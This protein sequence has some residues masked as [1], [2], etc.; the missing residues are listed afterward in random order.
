M[1]DGRTTVLKATRTEYEDDYEGLGRW[2]AIAAVVALA[3]GVAA[4][5][6]PG[7]QRRQRAG[8]ARRGG[9]AGAG[10]RAPC[11]DTGAAAPRRAAERPRRGAPPAG[12]PPGAGGGAF[13]LRAICDRGQNAGAVQGRR[14]VFG[15]GVV[16]QVKSVSGDTLVLQAR[17]G[18]ALRLKLTSSTAVRKTASGSLDDVK[19]G[20]TVTVAGTGQN[21]E[22]PATSITIL[23][24]SQ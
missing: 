18:E 13:L 16:G 4:R 7:R 20:V 1:S 5:S 9:P 6:S 17:Q 10:R 15:G 19:P 2:I 14:G 3:L 22:N 21:N 24:A 12:G 11:G 8:D 23:P